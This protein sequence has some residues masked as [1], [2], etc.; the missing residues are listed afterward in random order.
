MSPQT[1]HLKND[2]QGCLLVGWRE[3]GQVDKPGKLQD[4]RGGGG[5]RGGGGKLGWWMGEEAE[6]WS[7]GGG[8]DRKFGGEKGREG[9][10][11][12]GGA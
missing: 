9:R 5:S 12:N 6:Q 7:S 2:L 11:Q 4:V 3:K 1:C 10:R 8:G